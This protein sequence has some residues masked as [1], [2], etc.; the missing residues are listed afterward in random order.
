M[1]LKARVFSCLLALT[2][3]L[4]G[5]CAP[6]SAA[7]YSNLTFTDKAGNQVTYLDQQYQDIAELP[8]GTQIILTGMPD[9]NAAYSDGTYNRRLQHRQG[10]LVHPSGQLQRRCSEG[11][12][13]RRRLHH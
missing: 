10:H 8:I 13:A 11:D 7:K 5:L 2:L 1:K 12:R 4:S 6:A 3:G 9:Y